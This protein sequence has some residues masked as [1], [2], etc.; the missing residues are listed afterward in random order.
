MYSNKNHIKPFEYEI[1]FETK[2]IGILFE[3]L[4]W[5]WIPFKLSILNV[6]QIIDFKTI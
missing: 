3:K 5:F 4:N 1:S 6:I 2:L